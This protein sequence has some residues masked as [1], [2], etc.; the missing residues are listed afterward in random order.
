[1][2]VFV[3]VCAKCLCLCECGGVGRDLC[4]CCF[5]AHSPQASASTES[6][7]VW[8][9]FG[10]LINL[11]SHSIALVV[12]VSGGHRGDAHNALF[13]SIPGCAALWN[14]PSYPAGHLRVRI[15]VFVQ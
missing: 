12:G 14:D 5:S 1:M 2:D 3:F 6:R 8:A 11:S 13:A 4:S 10:Y 9:D 15:H 7:F